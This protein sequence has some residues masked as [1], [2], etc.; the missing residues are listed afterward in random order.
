MTD[1]TEF[2][3]QFRHSSRQY[4]QDAQAY[5]QKHRRSGLISRAVV[6]LEKIGVKGSNEAENRRLTFGEIFEEGQGFVLPVSA[7]AK[8]DFR[9]MHFTGKDGELA[10][11]LAEFPELVIRGEF[12]DRY[13]VVTVHQAEQKYRYDKQDGGETIADAHVS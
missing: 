6:L 4:L 3:L 8:Q 7:R 5:M 13:G 11:L 12:K 1:P 10:N 2:A 9:D